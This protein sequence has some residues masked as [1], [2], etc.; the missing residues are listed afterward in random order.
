VLELQ[1]TDFSQIVISLNLLH[2]FKDVLAQAVAELSNHF[3]PGKFTLPLN[4]LKGVEEACQ[5]AVVAY[6]K[7]MKP[8]DHDTA[9]CMERKS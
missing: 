6:G 1:G 2:S 5:L 7:S 9:L 4:F 8:K 3:F